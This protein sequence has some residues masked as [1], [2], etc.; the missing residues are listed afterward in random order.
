M[1]AKDLETFIAS[2]I[3]LA[4]RFYDEDACGSLTQYVAHC[5]VED[6]KAQGIQLAVNPYRIYRCPLCGATKEVHNPHG[7]FI[8]DLPC[9]VRG[10][11]GRAI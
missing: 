1:T 8:D 10:C 2:S 7:Q 9:G 11:E 3:D 4:Y 5:I 6:L